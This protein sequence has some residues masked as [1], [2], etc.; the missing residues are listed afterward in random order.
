MRMRA[1]AG[2][3]TKEMNADDASFALFPQCEGEG[4]RRGWR[5]GR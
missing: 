3:T 4:G 1:A 2:G 5:A